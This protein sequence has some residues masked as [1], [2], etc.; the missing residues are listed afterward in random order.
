M[1]WIILLFGGVF[2]NLK[3][4]TYA[5]VDLDHLKYNVELAHS[6]FKRPLMA[7]IKADAYGHGYK[8]VASFLKD[9][10]YI[11]MF[12]VA[13]LQEA[14][15]L[16]ELGINKGILILGAIPTSKED[17][18]LAIKYDISLTMVSV[19]YLKLLDHLIDKGQTLKVHIKLDTGMHRIGLMSKEE[20]STLLK[21]VDPD[22]FN[23]E[24]IFTHF[25]TADGDDEAYEKQRSLFYEMIGN[26]KFKY[27]HCCNS[28]AMTYHHDENQ[29]WED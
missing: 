17:I 1:G 14:I 8:E 25:A 22:K 5:I 7:V 2:M 4:D 12:A 29:I 20:L 26:C 23:V 11:E 24:G 6:E 16:R 10:D 3:R 15:E 28:A 19:A 18:D 9:I 27:I 13:T 21:L